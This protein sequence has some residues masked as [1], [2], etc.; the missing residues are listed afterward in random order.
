MLKIGLLKEIKNNEYRVALAPEGAKE[1]C[2]SGAV[3]LVEKDA[4]VGS[5]FSNEEYESN[6]AKI[7][8]IEEILNTCELI[9]KIKE[10]VEHEMDYFNSKHT[11]FTYFHFASN[12]ELTDKMVKSGANCIAYETVRNEKGGTPLLA[13]MSHVAGRMSVHIGAYYLAKP[14]NGSGILLQG[15]EGGAPAKVVILGGGNAGSNAV[16]VALGMGADVTV[17]ELEKCMGKLKEKFPKANVLESTQENIESSIIEADLFIGSIYVPGEKAKK[18][19]TKEMVGK[20]KKGSVIVD[21]AIDQGGSVETS[22]P[23]THSNPVFDVSGVTHYCVAN[24]PGAFPRTSTLGIT[25]ATLPYLKV[26][27][28]KGIVNAL[29]EDSGFL[30]GV[31]IWQGKIIN[32]GVAKAYGLKKEVLNL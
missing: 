18:L 1:L 24:M 5:G 14:N 32:E 2:S 25:N 8:T 16:D 15:I 9:L 17:L 31:N 28:Q 7:S 12:K 13:P 3:V 27:V 23:T 20:M 6:G 21:I 19:V 10:P 4:G 26:I 30:Q 29:K 22:K 11:I